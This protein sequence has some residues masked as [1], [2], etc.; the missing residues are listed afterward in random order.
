VERARRVVGVEHLVQIAVELSLPEDGVDVLRH[1]QQVE[2]LWVRVT[3][4]LGQGAGQ[5]AAAGGETAGLPCRLL[6]PVA[7]VRAGAQ[8]D[9]DLAVG[10]QLRDEHVVA[11][12][13]G[14]HA[15]SRAG[16]V[17]ERK[18][19]ARGRPAGGASRQSGW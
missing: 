6:R 2:I 12:D 5:L 15:S 7:Q 10:Q 11:I 9:D 3:A 16:T 17:G 18:T 13:R 1:P 8:E 4:A 14:R 19:A